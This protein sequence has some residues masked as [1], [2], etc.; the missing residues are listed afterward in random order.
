MKRFVL[1]CL[2]FSSLL[3]GLPLHGQTVRYA[4]C[5]EM[6]RAYISGLCVLLHEDNVVKGSLF[7]EFGITAIEFSYD[8]QK[9]KVKL[10]R[11]IGMLDKW[12][13]R[14]VLRRDLAR[15][16]DNVQRGEYQYEN[17]KRHIKY[18]LTPL[19]KTTEDSDEAEE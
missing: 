10:H 6:Q 17:R 2:L 4:A 8:V 14:R 13:I 16:M 1:T 19:T 15:L 11:V 3:P 12:Y 5:I 9:Q 7:N 18:K